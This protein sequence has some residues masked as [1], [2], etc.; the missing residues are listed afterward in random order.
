[1]SDATFEEGG[2]RPVF[3]TALDAEGLQVVSAL[4]QDSV[5]TVADM[6]WD[7]RPRRFAVLLNRFRWEDKAAAER[8]G[9]PYERVRSLLVVE[10]VGRVRSHGI[11]RGARDTVLSLLALTWEEADAPAG[12]LTLTLA[13]DG[14]VALDAECLD[15]TL[16]DVTKPYLAP[17]GKAPAHE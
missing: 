9:R 7:R 6:R 1:M 4:V 13:G 5:F 11:D 17:S 15:V 10:D 8:R 14:A 2:E 16:R 3:L 12:T